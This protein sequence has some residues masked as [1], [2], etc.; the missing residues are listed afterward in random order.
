MRAELECCDEPM[1]IEP[2]EPWGLIMH[3]YG[4]GHWEPYETDEDGHCC[5]DPECKDCGDWGPNEPDET[6]HIDSDPSPVSYGPAR[7]AWSDD[8]PF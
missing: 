5:G 7:E 2:S 6:A 8:C 1:Y 4:C 3:C